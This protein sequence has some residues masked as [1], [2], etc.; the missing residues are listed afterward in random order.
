MSPGILLLIG[1]L[2][3]VGLLWG[4]GTLLARRA[5]ARQVGAEVGAMPAPF[6]TAVQGDTLLWFHS[7]SCAPC[8]AMRA[9][10][11]ALAADGRL[12]P[13]DVTEHLDVARSLSVMST[14]T[15]IHVREGRVVEVRTGALPRAELE[16]MLRGSPA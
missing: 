10:A 4:A 2:V 12:H 11:E 16:R 15:T 6:D 3:A 9:D 14:P 1:V 8:R 7:A 13:I 5:R